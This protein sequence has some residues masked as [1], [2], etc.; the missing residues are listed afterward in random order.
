MDKVYLLIIDYLIL[1][2]L[3]NKKRN[4]IKRWQFIFGSFVSK[5]TT[6]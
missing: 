5:V 4:A 3:P 6:L 2:I 1:Y